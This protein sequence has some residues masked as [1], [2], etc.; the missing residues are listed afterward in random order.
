MSSE[1]C[2]LRKR[3]QPKQERLWKNASPQ[4]HG[5]FVFDNMLCYGLA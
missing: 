2:E 3:R 5:V 4:D 1:K